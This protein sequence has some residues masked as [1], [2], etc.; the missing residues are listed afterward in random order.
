MNAMNGPD[1]TGFPR[2]GGPS[3]VG[4]PGTSPTKPSTRTK[5]ASFDEILRGQFQPN[6]E[7]KL[8]GHAMNRLEMRNITLSKDDMAKLR[9]AVDRAEAKGA[10][11]ALVLMSRPSRDQDLALVVSVKN[12]TVITAMD[13]DN[14]RDN[15]FTNIDS[16]VVV[17]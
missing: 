8:S 9:D 17:G 12:R 2:V 7:V 1:G 3:Q 11:E 16:A 14:L 4:R 6:R 5:G 15:V 10:R 13:G